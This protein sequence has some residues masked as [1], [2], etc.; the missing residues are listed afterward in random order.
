MGVGSVQL[1]TDSNRLANPESLQALVFPPYQKSRKYML[2]LLCLI[3]GG[4]EK[5]L[6]RIRLFAWFWKLAPYKWE[7]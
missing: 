5:K 6:H 2:Q 4:P 3:P 7:R 1:Q